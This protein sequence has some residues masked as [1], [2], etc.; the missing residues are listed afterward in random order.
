METGHATRTLDDF[1]GLW[2]V[3]R[4]IRQDDG[5]GGR[6]EGRAEWCLDGAGADYVETGQFWLA[7]QGPF[8]AERRYRWTRDLTVF[9]DDGRVFHSVPPEGG[10]VAHWCPPD[11]YAGRYDFGD[12]AAWQVRWRVTGPRKAY[13]SV[14]RYVRPDSVSA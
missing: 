5:T 6:F 3:T 1:A 11:Q 14:T 12:G 9:F 4:R 8:H 10:E 7:E 13:T 2:T